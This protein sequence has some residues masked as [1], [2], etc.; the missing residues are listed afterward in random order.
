MSLRTKSALAGIAA[1]TLSAS[2]AHAVTLPFFQITANGSVDVSNQLILDVTALG[3]GTISF[4]LS[5]AGPL[6]SVITMFN[7]QDDDGLFSDMTAVINGAGV[8]FSEDA[9]PGN[10]PGGNSVSFVSDWGSTANPPPAHNGVNEGEEL[11]LKF[12]LAGGKDWSD[13]LDALGSGAL[14]AGL[15]VQSI[16]QPGGGDQSESYVSN[17]PLPTPGA[18]ALAAIGMIGAARRRR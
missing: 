9:P 8:D 4:D 16:D 15:H 7:I 10:L 18:L 2:A 1:V 13:V 6:S 5:N 14:R 17:P 12:S 11:E 3:G